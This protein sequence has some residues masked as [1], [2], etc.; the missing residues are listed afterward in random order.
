MMWLSSPATLSGNNEREILMTSAY[1]LAKQHLT[2][3]LDV[4]E[5]ENVKDTYC[6]ALIWQILQHYRE[7]GRTKSDIVR[8]IEFTLEELE[9]DGIFHVCRH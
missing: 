4:A 9:E 1:A 7:E 8:E 3:G 5:K 2:D 6:Q